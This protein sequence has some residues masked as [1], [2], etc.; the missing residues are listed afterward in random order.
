MELYLTP[1]AE[2]L[3]LLLTIDIVIKKRDQEREGKDLIIP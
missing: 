1:R 3:T 2:R